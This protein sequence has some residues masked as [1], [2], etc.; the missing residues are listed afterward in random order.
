M[1]N[2]VAT[3][4]VRGDEDPAPEPRRRAAPDRRPSTTASETASAAISTWRKPS[5]SG[6]ISHESS[7]DRGDQEHRHLG[8]RR[9]RDLGGELDLAAIGDDHGAAVLGGIPD[10]RDDHGSDEEVRQPDLLGE[11][12]ERA[13]EDLGDERR[14]DGRDAEHDERGLERPGPD[15]LVARDV[16]EAVATQRVHRDD[17]VDDEERDRDRHRELDDASAPRDRRS[18]SGSTGSGRGRSRARSP[19]RRGSSTSARSCPGR[20]RRAR[21]RARGAGSRRRSPPASRGRPRSAPR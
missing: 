10:D 11:R 17:Q 8:R 12:L 21:S 14:H 6:S 2:A 5:A 16:D 20:L 18:S 7:D 19:R 1:K 9:E 15:L 4:D 3:A 13:D